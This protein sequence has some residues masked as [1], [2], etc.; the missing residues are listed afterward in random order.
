MVGWIR[1]LTGSPRYGCVFRA[2]DCLS[3]N[4]LLSMDWMSASCTGRRSGRAREEP[5]RYI[6]DFFK[7]ALLT[8]IGQGWRSVLLS[9][10]GCASKCRFFTL[11]L[12][13]E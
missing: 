13:F 2:L 12:P 3:H 9:E 5:N 4:Y 11:G 7:G 1:L 6:G 10:T 8:P